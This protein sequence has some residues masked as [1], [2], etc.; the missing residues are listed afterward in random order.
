MTKIG[1]GC[2]Y[3]DI[4][5][6]LVLPGALTSMDRLL[7]QKEQAATTRDMCGGPTGLPA[8]MMKSLSPSHGKQA[9]L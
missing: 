9:N 4:A 7:S 8:A 3:F 2:R 5:S 1:A 6:P